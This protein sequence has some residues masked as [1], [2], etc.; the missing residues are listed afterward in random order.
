MKLGNE[1]T[2][3][4]FLMMKDSP[5]FAILSDDQI[6]AL[7]HFARIEHFPSGN[8]I[9]REGEPSVNFYSILEGQVELTSI[10]RQPRRLGHGEYFG[11]TTLVSSV[12]HSPSVLAVRDTRC[13]VLRGS[14]LRSYPGLAIKLLAE[15]AKRGP[16]LPLAPQNAAAMGTPREVGAGQIEF[17][18]ERAKVLFDYVVKCFVGDYMVDRLNFEQAGWRT[19]SELAAKTKI[20][21]ASLYGRRG[22]LGAF[23]GELKSR[24]L[25]EMRVFKGERGRG[26]EILKLR[27]AYD[28]EPVRRLVDKAITKA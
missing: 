7:T 28:K 16:R 6:E 22:S 19:V 4:L 9:L 25:I 14:V 18:S 5:I 26:G 15:S 23:V 8:L 21:R 24:G 1:T 11:E 2:T 13:I 27:V 17:K 20:P 10:G 3:E 12:T